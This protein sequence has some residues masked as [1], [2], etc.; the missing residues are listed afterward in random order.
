MEALYQLSYSP[1]KG[2]TTLP[3]TGTLARMSEA[4]ADASAEQRAGPSARRD[5]E[6]GTMSEAPPTAESCRSATTRASPTRSRRSGRTAG[7]ADHTFWAPNPAGPLRDGFDAVA[8]RRKL[9]VLDMFPYPSG[10]GLHVGHPLGYIGTDVYARFMRMNGR[11][12]LHAMGYDAFGLPAEQ[13]AVQTGQHPRVTTEANIANMRRQLRALGL[14]HDPRR[15]VATTDVRLLPVDAVDL[16][17]DLRLL[18]R[19]GRRTAPGRSP[20][21]SP[22]SRRARVRPTSDANPDGLAW[23]ELDAADA[24]RGRRLVPARVP[25]RGDRSTGAPRSAPCSPTKRSPPTAAASAATTRCSASAEAV[26]AAHHR[27]RRPAARRPRPARLARVDQDDAA[28][29]DRPQRRRR[30]S[31]SRSRSTRASTSRCSPRAPTRCS[32]RRTWCSRPSTRWS[33]RSCRASGPTRRSA[34]TSTTSPTSGG[35]SSAP[36]SCPAEAVAPYRDFAGAEDASSSA[37]PRAR[38]K[39]GVFTGAFAVNPTNGWNDPDLRR[40]LRAD[41]LRHRRDHGGARARPARLRV[42][43]GVRPADRRRGRARPTA[44]CATAGSTPTRRRRTGPRRTS[45]TASA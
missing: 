45:A 37:R 11:N 6:S 36:T 1:E 29:L 40:R 9:Y 17:A 42:R 44:G 41:G 19:R 28:Q 33:T 20:S 8:G 4:C 39:T 21:W 15:G 35:A 26:D 22:S 16:P 30:R 3:V 27:V 5:A 14:G 13:Y 10:A 38:E 24:A 25:R 18:V 34:R 12:V 23:A 43:A 2:A 31:R 32:A 7:S